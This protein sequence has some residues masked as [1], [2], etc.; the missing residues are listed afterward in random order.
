MHMFYKHAICVLYTHIA[1]YCVVVVAVV[2]ILVSRVVVS[3]V[4]SSLAEY[5][6]EFSYLIGSAYMLVSIIMHI[7][8]ALSVTYTLRWPVCAGA[9][10]SCRCTAVMGVCRLSRG[11]VYCRAVLS[12]VGVCW[13][14]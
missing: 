6:H 5:V 14:C 9:L 3:C 10:S 8:I 7:C 2:V 11:V 12:V 1:V 4:G 13:S